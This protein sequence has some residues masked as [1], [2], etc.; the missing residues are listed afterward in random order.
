[1]TRAPQPGLRSWRV[2]LPVVLWA[3]VAWLFLLVTVYPYYGDTWK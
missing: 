3:G 1:M 2:L